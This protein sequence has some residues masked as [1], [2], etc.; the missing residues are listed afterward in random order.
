MYLCITIPL[1]YAVNWLDRRLRNGRNARPV[2]AGLPATAGAL[3][4]PAVGPG[5]TGLAG[6]EARSS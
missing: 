2:P 3:P 6:Q 4:Q 1:T 5:S